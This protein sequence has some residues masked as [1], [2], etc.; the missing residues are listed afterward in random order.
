MYRI[1][2]ADDEPIERML[3]RKILERHFKDQVVTE[4]A[5]NGQDAVTVFRSEKCDI[6]ILDIEMPGINGIDAAKQIRAEYPNA[7]IIFLT[8]FD[9]FNYA[10]SAITVR[11]LDYLLKP[12]DKDE[13]LLTVEEAMRQIDNAPVQGGTQDTAPKEEN[14]SEDIL[15]DSAEGKLNAVRHQIQLYIEENYMEDIAVSSVAKTLHYSDAY[16]CKIFKQCFGMSFVL[17]LTQVRI[18]KAKELLAD[19]SVNIKEVSKM[20][21]YQ[22]SNYFTKVFKRMEKITPSEYRVKIVGQM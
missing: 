17:Y 10:R 12:T 3:A 22:D 8:A 15:E 13:L 21:G 9:D 18:E 19:L 11:A 6:A 4:I 2:I 5:E 16:F 14:V 1:L 7:Q 20:V